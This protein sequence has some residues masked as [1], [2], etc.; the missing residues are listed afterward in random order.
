MSFNVNVMLMGCS[1]ATVHLRCKSLIINCICMLL[2][3]WTG[4][5]IGGC[6]QVFARRY[7]GL[8]A[9]HRLTHRFQTV[10]A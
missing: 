10:D 5:E 3:P 9:T 2:S 6:R 7:V 4:G 1:L 8:C